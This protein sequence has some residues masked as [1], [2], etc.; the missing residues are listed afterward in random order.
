MNKRFIY[1]S[2]YTFIL[3]C[4]L[5]SCVAVCLLYGMF[6]DFERY[7]SVDTI[8]FGPI[9]TFL[10]IV[11]AYFTDSNLIVC[12]RDVAFVYG[13]S[14]AYQVPVE[15]IG[16]NV[17]RSIFD[18]VGTEVLYNPKSQIVRSMFYGMI[19]VDIILSII[20]IVAN[21]QNLGAQP[22]GICKLVFATLLIMFN[23]L[24]LVDRVFYRSR[25]RFVWGRFNPKV[26]EVLNIELSK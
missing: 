5:A 13:L 6:S 26:R 4:L 15:D 16:A 20:P 21:C 10:F 11:L 25:T 24:V 18:V 23:I 7:L 14:T 8:L 17:N 22:D 3:W 2:G 9:G 1:P 12:T 19:T